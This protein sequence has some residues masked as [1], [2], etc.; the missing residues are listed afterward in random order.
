MSISTAA[1]PKESII[2]CSFS[3]VV[4]WLWREG[5]RDGRLPACD[6]SSIREGNCSYD[7]QKKMIQKRS[8]SKFHKNLAGKVWSFHLPYSGKWLQALPHRVNHLIK[9]SGNLKYAHFKILFSFIFLVWCSIICD[10]SWVWLFFRF[11]CYNTVLQTAWPC[12]RSRDDTDGII[13]RWK[14]IDRTSIE[15]LRNRDQP[16]IS[17]Q[18]IYIHRNQ[19]CI[20][21][22]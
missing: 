5:W 3:G 10:M 12:L 22:E 21:A 13:Y 2:V 20:R 4:R 8:R 1:L 6:S 18:H 7:I 17:T 9:C 16:M 14:A 15:Q 11:I 19:W